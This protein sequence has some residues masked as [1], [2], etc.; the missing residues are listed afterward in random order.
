M[1]QTTDQ[2]KREIEEA[3]ERISET[4]SE[5]GERIRS[6]FDWRQQVAEHPWAAVGL[7]AAAGFLL[8][9]AG[10]RTM[11]GGGYEARRDGEGYGAGREPAPEVPP[12]AAGS[13]WAGTAGAA[14]AEAAGTAE[15]SPARPA[16]ETTGPRLRRAGEPEA[17]GEEGRTRPAAGTIV[18]ALTSALTPQLEEI[19]RNLAEQ[20]KDLSN[21]LIAQG[22]EFMK[23]R[24]D[25]WRSATRRRGPSE[26]PGAGGWAA[27]STPGAPAGGP[28]PGGST[29]SPE[30]AGTRAGG[31]ATGTGPT[32]GTRQSDLGQTGTR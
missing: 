11:R 28:P 19:G 31:V 15:P 2:I 13:E 18:G 16:G 8:G 23:E 32:A 21:Y 12:G 25:E 22:K 27:G 10:A 4:T 1:D 6:T 17:R 24:V 9:A 7:A 30:A 3:R 26:P 20:L 29:L 5:I 14:A